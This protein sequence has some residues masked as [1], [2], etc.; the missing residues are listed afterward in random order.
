[1]KAGLECSGIEHLSS[2]YKGPCFIPQHYRHTS[3]QK[4][5]PTHH[6]DF[7]NFVALVAVVVLVGSTSFQRNSTN[8]QFRGNTQHR[9]P[10]QTAASWLNDWVDF[11]FGFYFTQYWSTLSSLG[12]RGWEKQV[13]MGCRS[14][15]AE[16]NVLCLWT[17]P[18]GSA[19][20]PSSRHPTISLKAKLSSSSL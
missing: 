7:N 11:P 6:P 13:L 5:A 1:M 15:E 20:P 9:W 18:R 16:R 17:M 3:N 12:R 2:M 8:C 4:E 14:S 19:A 10:C